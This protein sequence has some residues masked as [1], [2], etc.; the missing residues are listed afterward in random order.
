MI[1][2]LHSC[3]VGNTPY[4]GDVK[5]FVIE[6]RIGK[7]GKPWTKI[8]NASADM[9]GRPHEVMSV[10]K[11]DYTDAHG[12]ISFN[13]EIQP[14]TIP[15]DRSKGAV[16]VQTVQQSS[17]NAPQ[18]RPNGGGY[19]DRGNRIERQHS[20]EMAIRYAA[21]KGLKDIT[22]KDMVALID[23]FARDVSRTPAPPKIKA[24]PEPQEDEAPQIDES[25]EF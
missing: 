8:T 20:Q 6:Q 2:G 17:G 4:V 5:L 1:S 16:P 12:H 24:K 3:T 22:P 7:S 21:L 18:T 14:V 10:T 11:T 15:E 13:M 25:E 9:G 23:W 19:E